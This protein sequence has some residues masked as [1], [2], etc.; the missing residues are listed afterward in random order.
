MDKNLR[1]YIR[2]ILQEH[3]LNED[4]S[5]TLTVDRDYYFNSLPRKIENKHDIAVYNAIIE[6]INQLYSH[7]MLSMDITDEIE[8]TFFFAENGIDNRYFEEIVEEKEEELDDITDEEI[9]NHEVNI[10]DY[11]EDSIVPEFITVEEAVI[12]ARGLTH[13]ISLAGYIL[14]NGEMLDFSGGQGE[15]YIDHRSLGFPRKEEINGTDLM[16]SFMDITGAIRIDGDS[17]SIHMRTHPTY[18]QW[19]IIKK[20]ILNNKENF[21]IDVVNNDKQ[22]HLQPPIYFDMIEEKIN[23]FYGKK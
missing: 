12:Q 2:K 14:Q 11:L 4:V 23:N 9:K 20:I 13:S 22:M 18:N 21:T 6:R 1:Q 10:E 15:R 8:D 19:K 7:R 3:F 5:K 17:G 16:L